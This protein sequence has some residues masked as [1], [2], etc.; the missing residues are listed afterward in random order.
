MKLLEFPDIGL[1]IRVE[2]KGGV[3]E[4]SIPRQECTCGSPLC[5]VHED[6]PREY[7]IALETIESLL[8]AL[9]CAG[10]ELE[11]D[12]IA[13]AVQTVIDDA[14]NRWDS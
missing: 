9:A 2:G 11:P 5:A 1:V 12:R 4:S 13:E 7:N 10:V 6:S 14:S 3:I 8:M